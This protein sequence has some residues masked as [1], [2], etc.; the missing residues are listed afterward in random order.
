MMGSRSR[1]HVTAALAALWLTACGGGGGSD[2]PVAVNPP[3]APAPNAPAPAPTPAPTPATVAI[4]TSFSVPASLAATPKVYHWVSSDAAG[5]VLLAGE[6]PSGTLSVS[7]DGGAT[8][9]TPASLP[10]GVWISSDISAT[11]DRMVAVQ[12]QGGGMF[13]STDKGT[14]WT[15]VTSPVFPTGNISFESVTMS[16]DGQRLAAV[17]QGGRLVI[18]NNGGTTW[19]TPTLPV[20]AGTTQNLPWRAVDS[21]A[22]G[23]VIVAAS[24][25]G[26]LFRSLDA[27]VTFKLIVDPAGAANPTATVDNWYRV[28]V[29]ADGKTIAV[30]G[31]TF[32]GAPGKG[33]YVSH[34]QGATF[35]NGTSLTIDYTALTMSA[36][37][38]TIAA[39][40]STTGTEA[41]RVLLS[42]N[43]GTSFTVVT[44]ANTN[45]PNWRA[46]A[47]S[48]DA[49]KL[50]VAAGKFSTNTPGQLY[51]SP[52]MP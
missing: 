15:Q 5:Q 24:Q 50:V 23:S 17:I 36:D 25:D 46:A 41:G 33:V 12:Y 10:T 9:T 21:S 22:D 18:S 44:P 4:G 31:N 16:Q 52:A 48:T 37:G 29:S 8:W 30:A 51:V 45:E 32:G 19:S 6:A 14:T 7:T 43:G 38:Q 11:G 40:A 20:S 1:V 49:K 42:T 2:S 34:D 3:P 26:Q 27:G 28:K 47:M 13:L 35:S 39:T